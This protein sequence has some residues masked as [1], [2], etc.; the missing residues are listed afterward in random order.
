[1]W[2]CQAK[3]FIRPNH[4]YFMYIS[5]VLSNNWRCRWSRKKD[6]NI[7]LVLNPFWGRKLWLEERSKRKLGV[8]GPEET[9]ERKELPIKVPVKEQDLWP[10]DPK[11]EWKKLRTWRCL[12]VNHPNY[13]LKA[14]Q[15]PIVL[16]TCK[17]P[18]VKAQMLCIKMGAWRENLSPV[19]G[20]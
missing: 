6:L 3:T 1:M 12:R 15:C 20:R 9:G 4:L 7:I 18:T 13:C 11:G 2:I 17:C 5:H 16:D 14:T 10:Q 19:Q 8:P